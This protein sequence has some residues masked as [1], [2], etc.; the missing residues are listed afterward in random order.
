MKLTRLSNNN[1]QSES[2]V[3]TVLDEKEIPVIEEVTTVDGGEKNLSPCKESDDHVVSP[4]LEE[5]NT[6]VIVH[7]EIDTAPS[8]V[9]PYQEEVIHEDMELT[10][11][12]E[13]T[14]IVANSETCEEFLATT[15]ES[16]DKSTKSPL[17]SDVTVLLTE[18]MN[19]D[20]EINIPSSLSNNNIQT[21]TEVSDSPMFVTPPSSPLLNC[22]YV[23]STANE[24]VESRKHPRPPSA[25]LNTDMPSSKKV[26]ATTVFDVPS[27]RPFVV[28]WQ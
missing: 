17:H 7:Q 1:V 22:T 6:N 28:L 11:T 14:K 8:D 5:T 13:M 23:I 26:I 24:E 12:E 19:I 27:V 21:L 25:E 9:I 10:E 20:E 16:E 15:A 4:L 3:Q 2:L 18:Q